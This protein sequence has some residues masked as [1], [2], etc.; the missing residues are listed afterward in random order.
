MYFA[1]LVR[2]TA[3]E[4]DL[5]AHNAEHRA[6]LK[7]YFDAGKIVVSGPFVPRTGGLLIFHTDTREE[8]EAILSGDPF[9]KRGYYEKQVFEWGPTLGKEAFATITRS[10]AP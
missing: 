8:L 2:Y 1:V 3:D 9:G 5:A 10:S 6:Y 4:A 7:P